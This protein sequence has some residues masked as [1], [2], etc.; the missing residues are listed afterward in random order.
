MAA[1][2]RQEINIIDNVITG[3]TDDLA[4]VQLDTTQYNG[5][6]LYYFEVVAKIASGS[7]NVT[8]RRIGGTT[9]DA[10]VAVT[11]STSYILF[12]STAFTPPAGQTTY[13]VHCA[14][15][16]A[17]VL[18]ARIIVIQTAT[19]LTNTETQIEIG[20]ASTTTT[21]TDTALTN[22]K[23]W[24]YNSANWDGTITAYFEGVFLTATSKSAATMTLQVSDSSSIAAP[25]W[26][27]VTSSAVTTTSTT[28]ARVRS[29][30][31]TLT[32]DRWY[33]AVMKAG[34]SK[35]GI[36]VYRAGIVVDSYDGVNPNTTTSADGLV[37]GGTAGAGQSDQ[38]FGQTIKIR[39]TSNISAVTLYLKKFASPVD[40]LSVD[41]FA[42][43]GIGTPSGASL[44]NA[45]LSGSTLTTSY[46]A[47]TLTFGSPVSLTGGTIY[48]ILVSRSPD[49]SDTTNYYSVK[50]SSTS[51]E[52]YSDGN[53][54]RR[55]NN[56]W[57]NA[58]KG[59][60][61]FTFSGQ[62]GITKLEPQYLL[63]NTLLAAGTALQTFLT[64]WDSTEWDAGSGTTTFT[65]QAEAANG[66]T[67]DVLIQE[68]DAGS[69]VATI[70]NIDNAGTAAATM[71]TSQ[72]L[73]CLAN[74]NAG[75]VAAVRLLVAY[76]F[77]AAAASAIKTI[78][79]L[80]IASVS[81][82]NG[83]AR[84]SMKNWNGLA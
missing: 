71:P 82:I 80:A 22:P 55:N 50:C 42:D 25:S 40:T 13:M 18:S 41:I 68:A 6:V 84:A 64:K 58:V 17:N 26:S 14:S 79:G 48:W 52:Q 45:T 83:L 73:D 31:I 53:G 23:Y 8:L 62:A 35:S 63:A 44:A 47:T 4:Q 67:S 24:Y 81:K 57:E 28:A 46:V 77:S 65:G 7:E 54:A 16:N 12:R 15:T 74:A 10:T 2:I 70:N 29:A 49:T 69:T 76:V 37:Q 30:A 34:N 32:A 51:T 43:S 61:I 60:A 75:D 36:T 21:T 5:T 9:D 33:R 39:A 19:T 1:A 59:D 3:A 56:S 78:N 38:A 11:G 66:S 27:N 72:N 20:N